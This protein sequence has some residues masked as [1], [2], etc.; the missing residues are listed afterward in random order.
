MTDVLARLTAA[1]ADRYRIERE[2]G[3]GGMATVYLAQDL[4]HDRQVALKVLKPELAAVIG[5]ERFVVEI[6]TTAALQHPHIL[7]LFDSG[8]A[9]GFLYY[10]MP[11]I[12]GETLRSKLDRETQLGIDEAVKITVAVADAL[13]YAHRH[14]VI[15]RDIKPENILMHDGR[16][17]VAD[18]GIALALSAAAGGRMTETG[19]SLGTPHYM[20]PEQAT[21]DKEITGRSDIY[22][23]GSVLY[24]MLTGEPPHMGKSAQ[25][26]IMKIVSDEARP[27]TELR[28]SVPPN[29]AAAV[30]KSL[31][32]LPADRFA[33]AA[34]FAAALGNTSFATVVTRAPRL[35]AGPARRLAAL[36]W[37]LAVVA[38][39]AAFLISRRHPDTGSLPAGA[40]VRGSLALG[41]SAVVR[42][43]G[44]LRLA[45]D[46][47]GRRVA[48]VGPEGTGTMLWVRELD[49]ESARPLPGTTGAFAPFFS[50][51]GASIGFFSHLNSGTVMKVI[52]AQGGVARTVVRD[53]VS[54]YGGGSW[55]DDGQIYF[56]SSGRDLVRVSA[57]GGAVSLVAR[58]DS[59][60][61]SSELDFPDAVPGGR[62]VL[63]M[64]WLGSIGSNHVGVV[65]T[66]TGVVTD[67]ATGSFIRYVAPGF[68]AIGTVDG[69]I[70]GARFDPEHGRLLGAPTLMLQGVQQ[71]GTNGTV[72]FAVSRTGLL[73]Y[74][75][76]QAANSGLIWVDRTGKESSVDTSSSGLLQNVALSPDGSRIAVAQSQDGENQIWVKQ[77]ATRTF[78]R[79]SFGVSNADRPVWTPDG[80]RVAFLAT[81]NN[82][83]TAWSARADG[84]GDL[85]P[86][87]PPGVALDEIA[88]DPQGRYTLFRSEGGNA[89]SRHLMVL[90]NGRDTAART[91]LSSPSDNYAMSVSPD[92]KWLAYV[93]TE[94]GQADVYVRPFPSVDSARYSISVGGG[95]EPV[96]RRDGTELFFRNARGDLYATKVTTGAHFDHAEP[97]LLFTAPGLAQQE[98][99]R[100][101]DVASDGQRFLMVSSGGGDAPELNVVFNWRNELERLPKNAR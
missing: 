4:R 32:K 34:E 62:Y 68:V 73:A 101:Y 77:L 14:G 25:Q 31:E 24:E 52:P 88:F 44:D 90:E 92:G 56:T 10:V 87:S 53:S 96:W 84:S 51:D 3:A 22:S 86:A 2:L 33:T 11:F 72:Q 17:V 78:T 95:S 79:L 82:V 27:V 21:A 81:K 67:L 12:D 99:F 8:N 59:A 47:A 66:K 35:T 30:A 37:A 49:Q 57:A 5:A 42:A 55:G 63:V 94:S 18:F 38:L 1:L 80:R 36:P 61:A 9:D 13:D 58:H 28:K 75:R 98:Y 26:I 64:L 93:S 100:A 54:G 43:I 50:P 29:V 91:L 71:E 46:P 7:P 40:V 60:Y 19:M 70:L 65:D 89:G 74:Q 83:R 41:D 6:K 15:H 48:F 69:S 20:S 76:T 85:Q 16:P 39:L 23:L 97:V 45:L